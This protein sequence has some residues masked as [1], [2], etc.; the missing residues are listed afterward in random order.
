MT[1]TMIQRFSS[2]ALTLLLSTTAVA[3]V[4]SPEADYGNGNQ[5]VADSAL[6]YFEGKMSHVVTT[7]MVVLNARRQPAADVARLIDRSEANGD[8]ALAIPVQIDS[9][10]RWALESSGRPDYCLIAMLRSGAHQPRLERESSIAHEAFHC[11][12]FDFAGVDRTTM[13]PRWLV[14]GSA[15]FAGEDFS[16]G[17][18]LGFSRYD[19]MI[20]ALPSHPLSDMV[21]EIMP[22]YMH[23]HLLG[24]DQYAIIKSALMQSGHEASWNHWVE[25][26]ASNLG[27]FAMSVI[28][29]PE[30]SQ[31]WDLLA[32]HQTIPNTA[33][34]TETA[35]ATSLPVSLP[36]SRHHV[37]AFSV[38]LPA[39]KF[40]RVSFRHA[41]GAIR[42]DPSQ[43]ITG[44]GTG[45]TIELQD[46]GSQIFCYGASCGCPAGVDAY[47]VKRS[48][49]GLLTISVIAPLRAGEVVFEEASPGCCEGAENLDPRLV[50]SW[51]METAKYLDSIYPANFNG[52]LDRFVT[53]ELSVQI[54]RNGRITKT[55][56]DL[57]V[58]M[59]HTPDGR[60][61]ISNELHDHGVVTA[62]WSSRALGADRGIIRFTGK[63][64][65]VTHTQAS[66]TEGLTP[67]VQTFDHEGLSVR[68]ESP[69]SDRGTYQLISPDVLQIRGEPRTFSRESRDGKITTAKAR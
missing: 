42:L 5:S 41:Q 34:A 61:R 24:T 48:Q 39:N 35:D 30:W 56:S 14:E 2:F 7:P 64:D 32:V 60:V 26:N 65:G 33:L 11:L 40:V 46:S 59:R 19:Q 10:G 53:G 62:C 23:L 54:E 52:L 16:G 3:W 57:R 20:T 22:M 47:D 63:N 51:K 27:K 21:Y 9:D 44:T 29:K 13:L 36:I 17:S 67:G 43:E 1:P 49:E 6:R 25:R 68:W 55:Y 50:G 15:E 66:K 38:R 4:H 18:H 37:K 28:R 69:G 12:Q 45:E 58:Y 8:I 31:D